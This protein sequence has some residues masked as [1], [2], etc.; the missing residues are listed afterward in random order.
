M[1]QKLSDFVSAHEQQDR[2]QDRWELENERILEVKLMQ[3][4]LWTKAGSMIA[5]A[6]QP[7]SVA[8]DGDGPNSPYSAALADGMRQPA[9]DVFHLFN[10]V[11]LRVQEETGGAQVPWTSSSPIRTDVRFGG[12]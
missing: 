8:L 4:G 1:E 7:G 6:T 9:A 12:V 5:Y 11:G 2:G 10:G 3:N